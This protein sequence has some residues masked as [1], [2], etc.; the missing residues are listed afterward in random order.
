MEA[1]HARQ[2]ILVIGY[3][4][5]MRSDDGVGRYIAEVVQD[6]NDEYVHALSH[7][8]LMPELVDTIAQYDSVYFVDA[9]QTDD[10]TDIVIEKLIAKQER[11]SM[12]HT[13][14]PEYL[15]WLVHV[16]YKKNITAWI[17]KIPAPNMEFGERF[18]SVTHQARDSALDFFTI[19]RKQGNHADGMVLN[20][21]SLP[22]ERLL[23]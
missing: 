20:L 9:F 3:G 4:N 8:Q 10:H 5:T 23:K 1:E 17:V 12:N 15:L 18:S 22:D 2:K 7:H 16:L 21:S 11:E 14:T 6:W 19:V 13:A